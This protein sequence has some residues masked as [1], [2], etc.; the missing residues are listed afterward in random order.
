M[1]VLNRYHVQVFDEAIGLSDWNTRRCLILSS[2]LGPSR[3]KPRRR[4]SLAPTCHIVK[5]GTM[6]TSTSPVSSAPGQ[7]PAWHTLTI[8]DALREQGV[9]AA[10]GLSPA[11]AE[12]R[13]KKYG[14]NAFTTE[15]K[16][17]GYV[18]FLNQYRDPMQIV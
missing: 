2:R 18:A 3:L 6:T 9:D 16:E 5:E 13:L 14:T 7:G 8:E 15:Q 4:R 11:E 12:T 10:T 1:L 17:P